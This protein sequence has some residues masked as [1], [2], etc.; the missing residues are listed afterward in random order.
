LHTV[1]CLLLLVTVRLDGLQHSSVQRHASCED[2]GTAV[3]CLCLD[4]SPQGE[5]KC[6]VIEDQ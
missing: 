5:M 2:A 1:R 4:S 3:Q 6:M